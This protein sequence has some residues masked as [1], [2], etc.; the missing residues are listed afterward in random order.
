M[1][2]RGRDGLATADFTACLGHRRAFTPARRGTRIDV[3]NPGVAAIRPHLRLQ[4]RLAKQPANSLMGSRRFHMLALTST[5]LAR[6][7]GDVRTGHS[8]W[9]LGRFPA[10]NA[11]LVVLAI[12]V[13]GWAGAVLFFAR[14]R[15]RVVDWL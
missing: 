7:V 11:W 3:W 8:P 4:W 12:A 13:I 2:C 1:N 14:F 5:P 10:L 15:S 9:Q 6:A